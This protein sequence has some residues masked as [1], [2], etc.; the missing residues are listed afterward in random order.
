L[1]RLH[2]ADA[3]S[4]DGGRIPPVVRSDSPI[5]R[6]AFSGEVGKVVGPLTE[7]GRQLWMLVESRPVPLTGAWPELAA[8]VEA[9]LAQRPVDELEM[10]QWRSAMQLRYE[11]DFQPFLRLVGQEGR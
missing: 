10:A 7:A 11:V 1:A 8:A 6:L 3:S 5:G 2:S 9:D 4:A